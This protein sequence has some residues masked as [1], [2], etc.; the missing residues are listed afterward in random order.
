MLSS[1]AEAASKHWVIPLSVK[2][3]QSQQKGNEVGV[4]QLLDCIKQLALTKQ[5]NICCCSKERSTRTPERIWR[6]DEA[7]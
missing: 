1:D 3:V 6:Q 5:L 7:Q 2:R 4:Q